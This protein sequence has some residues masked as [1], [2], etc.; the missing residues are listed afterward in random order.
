MGGISFMHRDVQRFLI[1]KVMYDDDQYPFVPVIF[2]YGELECIGHLFI[3]Q[4]LPAQVKIIFDGL[5]RVVFFDDDSCDPAELF[6]I[7]FCC[8]GYAWKQKRQ[9]A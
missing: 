3:R 7:H 4:L 6:I 2:L 1:C 9:K 5:T 8:M